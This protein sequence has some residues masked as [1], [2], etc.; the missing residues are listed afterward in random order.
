MKTAIS[1]PD[2]LFKAAERAAK[3]QKVS[4]S[5]LYAKALQEYLERRRSKAITKALNEI[6]GTEP[7]EFDP[8]LARLQGEALG[9]ADW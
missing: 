3:R 4:R 6:Y 5:R 2:P 1:I 8:V 7:S 9:R